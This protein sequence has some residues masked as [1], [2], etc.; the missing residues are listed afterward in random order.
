MKNICLSNLEHFGDCI[1]KKI[2]AEPSRVF[3]GRE[4]DL[5][6]YYDVVTFKATEIMLRSLKENGKRIHAKSSKG[7]ATL[8]ISQ[9]VI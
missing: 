4:L 6:L 9:E 2:G 5:I 3:E 7:H 8:G 1:L